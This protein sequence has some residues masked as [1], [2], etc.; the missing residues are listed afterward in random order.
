MGIVKKI[1]LGLLAVSVT[2]YSTSA[3][4][5]FVLHDYVDHLIS[6]STFTLLTFAAGIFWTCL[7]GFLAARWYIRP[8]LVLS[9]ASGQ[10]A[11][12]NLGVYVNDNPSQDELGTLVRAF[13]KM[14]DSLRSMIHEIQKNSKIT[15]ES[16]NGLSGALLHATQQIEEIAALSDEIRRGAQTQ[17]ASTQAALQSFHEINAAVNEIT[18]ESTK[19]VELTQLMYRSLQEGI[20]HIQS[21]VSGMQR[22]VESNRESVQQV[23]ELQEKA[24]QINNFSQVVGGIASQTHLLALNASIEAAHAGELGRGFQVVA[25]EI[26]KLAEQSADAVSQIDMLIEVTQREI[27]ETVVQIQE[28]TDLGNHEFERASHVT[29]TLNEFRESTEHVSG[30]VQL[31]HSMINEQAHHFQRVL[32]EVGRIAEI[33]GSIHLNVREVSGSTESQTAFMQELVA[34]FDQLRGLANELRDQTN[35]FRLK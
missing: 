9:K 28:Q 32:D 18:N 12:G 1:V 21:M 5:I 14:L 19:A 2:T 25:D 33:A 3:F 23:N 17:E 7:L 20:V 29:E 24:E 8:L 26:R 30:A 4:F 22:L 27:N 35:K 13:R 16:V 11:L 31:I 6:A 15:N 10:A 34:T